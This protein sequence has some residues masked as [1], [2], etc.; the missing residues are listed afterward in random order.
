MTAVLQLHQPHARPAPPF[1]VY[2]VLRPTVS[3]LLS[4]PATSYPFLRVRRSFEFFVNGSVPNS[5]R[6]FDIKKFRV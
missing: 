2:I 6:Q 1:T 5:D 3:R 4:H